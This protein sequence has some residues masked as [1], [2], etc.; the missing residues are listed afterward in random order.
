MNNNALAIHES[1]FYFMSDFVYDILPYHE[2]LTDESIHIEDLI[3]CLIE[4]AIIHFIKSDR[5]VVYTPS[6]LIDLV[7]NNNQIDGADNYNVTT[8]D[9]SDAH[10]IYS[11]VISTN[12]LYIIKDKILGIIKIANEFDVLLSVKCNKKYEHYI[13]T[14]PRR[15]SAIPAHRKAEFPS[16]PR[17]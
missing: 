14:I 16:I 10:H 13:I 15:R 7:S 3:S 11:K 2:Y 4:I 8:Q 12:L 5:Q 6:S 17:I 1:H 9:I